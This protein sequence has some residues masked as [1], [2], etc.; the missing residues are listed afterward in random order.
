M[1]AFSAASTSRSAWVEILAGMAGYCT[2]NPASRSDGVILWIAVYGAAS[3][4]PRKSLILRCYL[5]Q[6]DKL[7]DQIERKSLKTLM[8]MSDNLSDDRL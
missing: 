2:L 1:Y 7:T 3:G 4:F 8:G 5:F 6:S